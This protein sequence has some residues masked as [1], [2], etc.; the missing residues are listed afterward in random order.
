ME[1]AQGFEPYYHSLTGYC[2][3]TTLNAHKPA[4]TERPM[5]DTLGFHNQFF[6]RREDIL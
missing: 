4:I 1:G 5:M 6:L 2:V 3:T